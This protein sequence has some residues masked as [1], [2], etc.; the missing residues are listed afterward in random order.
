MGKY[1]RDLLKAS[2]MYWICGMPDPAKSGCGSQHTASVA[3]RTADVDR[4][5]AE[6]DRR[7][8]RRPALRWVMVVIGDGRPHMWR[9][10]IHTQV[11]VASLLSPPARQ[12]C[13]THY[14]VANHESVLYCLEGTAELHIE[15]Q[16]LI[17]SPG[18]SW[19]VPKS[20]NHTYRVIEGPFK[21][22]EATASPPTL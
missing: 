9:G 19:M 14:A 15:N 5:E 13:A 22:L 20:C 7:P 18:Q 4:R 3:G 2:L 6:R 12:P 17:I 16:K 8:L 10:D 11:A 1:K 21:A